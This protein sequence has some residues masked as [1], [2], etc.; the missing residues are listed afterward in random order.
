MYF[1][2]APMYCF[3]AF[4]TISFCHAIWKIHHLHA[5]FL[6]A[7]SI[8]IYIFYVYRYLL[9]I[10]TKVW[11]WYIFPSQ[12]FHLRFFFVLLYIY[13]LTF[14]LWCVMPCRIINNDMVTALKRNSVYFIYILMVLWCQCIEQVE[15]L[16]LYTYLG[17]YCDAQFYILLW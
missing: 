4:C 11:K 15:R 8:N 1:L 5:N 10:C 14:C 3:M 17:K 2:C 7:L 16:R 13:F 6:L 12:F 9:Y